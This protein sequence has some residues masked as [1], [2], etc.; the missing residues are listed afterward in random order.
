MA[1]KGDYLT[2]RETEIWR[3]RKKINNQSEIGRILG[4]SRQAVNISL[5][6][7]T[8]KID[9]TFQAALDTNNL[10]PRKINLVEGVVEAYSPAY[11][12]PV[13]ISL[14]AVNGLK[15]WYLYDGNCK[16][17]DLE[18]SCRRTLLD[19]ARE[20]GLELE[21]G[22]DLLEPTKLA[23]KIFSRYLSEEYKV[24]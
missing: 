20:R 13:I 7:I 15:V 24:E 18:R 11:K 23:V 3:L 1:F 19:E 2:A 10:I 14:S 16:R 8:E 4:I 9:K 5:N 12:L 21:K 22:D 17:C 6:V